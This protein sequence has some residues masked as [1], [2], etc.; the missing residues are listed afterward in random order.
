MSV[1]DPKGA[2][3]IGDAFEGAT[4]RWML[5]APLLLGLNIPVEHIICCFRSNSSSGH[6][7]GCHTD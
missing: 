3:M 6:T 1:T 2:K 7:E 4:C 5:V